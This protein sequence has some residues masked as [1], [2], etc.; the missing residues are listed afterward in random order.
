MIQKNRR[1]DSIVT[2]FYFTEPARRLL[3]QNRDS[4]DVGLRPVRIVPRLTLQKLIQS[5]NETILQEGIT[6]RVCSMI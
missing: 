6:P 3:Q 1:F 5:R 2:N 4:A